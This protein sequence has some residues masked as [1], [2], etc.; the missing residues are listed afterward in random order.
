MD[1]DFGLPFLDP[2]DAAPPDMTHLYTLLDVE[3]PVMLYMKLY[4]MTMEIYH[5]YSQFG[6]LYIQSL[7]LL[8]GTETNMSIIRLGKPPIYLQTAFSKELPTH[9]SIPHIPHTVCRSTD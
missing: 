3:V 4:F 5:S 6:I 1:A 2:R 9:S 7:S 8:F